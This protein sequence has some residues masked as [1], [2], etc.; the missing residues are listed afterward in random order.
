MVGDKMEVILNTCRK[1]DNDQVKEF[2]F[3]D[4]ASLQDKL[5][6][7]Y[8]NPLDLKKL[9]LSIKSN[10][11]ISSKKSS[12]VVKCLEDPKVPEGMILLPVSIWSNQLTEV[13]G[14]EIQYKN[15]IVNIE[16]TSDSILSFNDILKRIKG[17]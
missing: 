8:L 6:V 9:E 1:I 2:I 14:E 12:I 10:I 17:S 11:K 16:P 5:A 3:G 15:I 13:E 7:S 4:E